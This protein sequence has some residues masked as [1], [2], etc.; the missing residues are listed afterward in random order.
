MDFVCAVVALPHTAVAQTA[1]NNI[2][3]AAEARDAGD[4]R[5]AIA[6][7]EV[8]QRNRPQDPLVLHRLGAV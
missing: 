8:E 5:A 7:L 3:R 4:Y 6:L 1:S 2:N